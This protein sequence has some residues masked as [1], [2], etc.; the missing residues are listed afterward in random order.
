MTKASEGLT[1]AITA[2]ASLE[3]SHTLEVPA[4]VFKNTCLALMDRVH[5]E[6][7][8]VVITKHGKPVARL[9]PADVEAPSALGFMRGTV[10]AEG[11]IV[12]PDFEAWGE[13]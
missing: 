13:V 5:D 10:V 4:G 11:D 1:A 9:V 2:S 12:S 3:S 6:R 7:I 8:H